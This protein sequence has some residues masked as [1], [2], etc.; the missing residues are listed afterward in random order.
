MTSLRQIEANRRKAID[1][2][3]P[4]TPEGKAVVAR[5]A[6]KHGLPSR[7]LLVR[8]EHEADLSAFAGR[9]RACLAPAD[10]LELLLVDRIVAAGW[11]LRRLGHV[12]A[13]LL[14]QEEQ[15]ADA[16]GHH[17][18]E[19][20]LVLSRYEGA[21]ERGL[22]L[23]LRELERVQ[24]ARAS[25]RSPF[26]ARSA[27][28]V[29]TLCTAITRSRKAAKITSSAR[30]TSAAGTSSLRASWFSSSV[31]S[32]CSLVGRARSTFR[33]SFSVGS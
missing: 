7:E 26:V 21:I 13:A 29:A 12:E 31:L 5:N 14:D 1:S 20:M 18:R 4:R 10:E 25:A 17:G 22:Y 28:T 23:A 15:P 11:R 19:K 3:G 30:R 33:S 6:L 9:L 2:T 24:G 16:F 8:G 32:A 27:M